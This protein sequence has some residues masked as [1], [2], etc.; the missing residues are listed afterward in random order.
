MRNAAR[1]LLPVFMFLLAATRPVQGE[2]VEIYQVQY[3]K[4]ASE[5]NPFVKAMEQFYVDFTVSFWKRYQMHSGVLEGN[6]D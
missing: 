3:A 1:I 5:D 4:G 6:R 2:L